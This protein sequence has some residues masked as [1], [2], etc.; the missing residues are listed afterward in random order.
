MC[1]CGWVDVDSAAHLSVVGMTEK[2]YI[3][4]V[5]LPFN[6]PNRLTESTIQGFT[7]YN[8]I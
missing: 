4:Q 1:A 8:Q 2:H 3:M 5:H 7:I 6:W